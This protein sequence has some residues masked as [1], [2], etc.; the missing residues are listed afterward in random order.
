MGK[1]KWNQFSKR[2]NINQSIETIFKSW[3]SQDQLEKWFLSKAQFFNNE[4]LIKHRTSIVSSKNTYEWMWHGSD[5]I[6][7]GEII[8]SNNKDYLKFTFYGCHVEIKTYVEHGENMIELTQS[9][10]PLDESSKM[11]YFV[12]CSGGWTF[13]LANLKSVLEGGLDLRNRN[14]RLTDVIN[15]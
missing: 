5:V 13:Y 2:I 14:I 3:T 7:K 10:I 12:G 8:E 15:T 11:D 6:A 1:I 4:N 9:N